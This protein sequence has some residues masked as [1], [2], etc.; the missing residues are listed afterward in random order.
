M[1]GGHFSPSEKNWHLPRHCHPSCLEIS[2]VRRSPGEGPPSPSACWLGM[3]SLSQYDLVFIFR[4][5][6]PN[7]ATDS[8]HSLHR[9]LNHNTNGPSSG[10][11]KSFFFHWS[12]PTTS[13]LGGGCIWCVYEA[14]RAWSSGPAPSLLGLAIKVK[15][16]GNSMFLA[17]SDWWSRRFIRNCAPPPTTTFAHGKC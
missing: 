2:D 9:L 6:R 17:D 12:H 5:R 15:G 14:R 4:P 11:N 16:K 1:G 3:F 13:H 8:K 7:P 10:L